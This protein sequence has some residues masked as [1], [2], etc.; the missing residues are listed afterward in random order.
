[1]D[2]RDLQHVIAL[3]DGE[4]RFTDDHLARLVARLRALGVLDDTIV[5]VTS[6]HGEEFFEHGQKGHAKTLYDE[7]LR[8]PLVVRHPRRIAPGRRV[9]E[10][11]R[12]MDVAPTI[13]GLA[14]V[15]APAGFGATGLAPEHR[16][17]DLA[18][19]L[20]EGQP[21]HFPVLPAFSSNLWLKG[22]QNAL[23]TVD[24][25]LIRYEPP[26]PKRPPTEVFDLASDPAERKNLFGTGTAA[27]FLATLDPL[28]V[29]W[30]AD[31]GRQTKLALA[32]KPTA[33]AEERLRAL[34]YVQ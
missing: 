16:F 14:G 22:K 9:A 13:L 11:V 26:L 1:M 8:V 7:V 25:K 19:Y 10:Q 12:L 5:V 31:A 32:R 17:A 18:R 30:R 29:A 2:P 33:Q 21:G 27:P 4:I 20:G 23:R 24:A 34:G 6:D 15:P 28:L 3:Y